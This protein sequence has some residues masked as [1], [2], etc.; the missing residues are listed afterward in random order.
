MESSNILAQFHLIAPALYRPQYCAVLALIAVRL[1][2]LL[3]LH[4]VRL[5]TTAHPEAR[6]L[7]KVFANLAR[8]AV[9]DLSLPPLATL[10]CSALRLVCLFLK[11]ARRVPGADLR[12]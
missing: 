4:F 2:Y 7:L 9:S 10:V 12:I 11:F 6:R 3:H 1:V 5:A 8:T